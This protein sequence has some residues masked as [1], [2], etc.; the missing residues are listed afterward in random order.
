MFSYLLLNKRRKFNKNTSQTNILLFFLGGG[1]KIVHLSAIGSGFGSQT[2]LAE[3]EIFALNDLQISPQETVQR[4]GM[5]GGSHIV[6]AKDG[7]PA[8][9]RD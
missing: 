3:T 9:K 6:D 1:I 4:K 8:L 2:S 7:S 5:H